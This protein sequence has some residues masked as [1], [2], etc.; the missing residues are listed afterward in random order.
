MCIRMRWKSKAA[1]DSMFINE[2][3]Y[4]VGF[5][6]RCDMKVRQWLLVIAVSF[7]GGFSAVLC[8]CTVRCCMCVERR[9]RARQRVKAKPAPIRHAVTAT[10]TETR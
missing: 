9:A 3:S 7:V 4:I 8:Y 2:I 10:A 6:R 5:R 1:Y